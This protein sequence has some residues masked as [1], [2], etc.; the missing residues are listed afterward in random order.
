MSPGIIILIVV[1]VL[2]LFFILWYIGVYNRLVRLRV[3]VKNA[4]ANIDVQLKRRYD[5]IPNL[6]ETVKGYAAHEKAVFENVTA[7]RARCLEAKTPGQVAEAE[8]F[9]RGALLNLFAVAENYPELKANEN[10]MSLQN[11]LS[12][13]EN[14][15]SSSRTG[16]NNIVREYNTNIQMFPNSVVAGIGGFRPEEFFE[17]APEERKEVE[18]APRVK[19]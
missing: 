15:I 14:I 19:F 5:L 6:V 18:R 4:W 12:N 9:L 1:G 10:F 2:L 8:G 17:I 3:E 11:E 16:Y 13:T 7:A